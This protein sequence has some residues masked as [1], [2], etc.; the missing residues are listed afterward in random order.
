MFI[1]NLGSEMNL[2]FRLFLL[3]IKTLFHSR[4]KNHIRQDTFLN[5]RVLP[6]DLDLN[7]H[8]NN[9]RYL[10]IMDLGRIDYMIKTGLLTVVLRNKWFPVIS[11]SHMCYFRPLRLFDTY[12]LRTSL[13]SW[14]DKSYIMTQRFEKNGKIYAIGLIRGLFKDKKRSISIVEILKPLNL[15]HELPPPLSPESEI[16]LSFVTNKTAK[17]LKHLYPDS[18]NGAF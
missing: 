16:W 15:E 6:N 8:M 4:T 2:Y 17:H 18:K 11:D 12:T 14:D 13:E 5:L 7:R 3:F 9:G 10:T 1:S